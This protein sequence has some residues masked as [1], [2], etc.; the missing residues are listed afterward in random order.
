MPIDITELQKGAVTILT[1]NGPLIQEDAQRFHDRAAVLFSKSHGRIVVDLA[2]VPFVDS[3]GLEVLLDLND[4][5][6][7]S[8]QSLKLCGVNS[9]LREVLALTDLSGSFEQF[10]DAD[11]AVRSFL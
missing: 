7:Q 9:T 11:S 6:L 8:G 5:L 4:R 3:K 1:A 10:Q 2:T